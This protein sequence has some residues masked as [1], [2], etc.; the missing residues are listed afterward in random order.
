MAA[1][2]V[3]APPPTMHTLPPETCSTLSSAQLLTTPAAIAKELIDNA[4]DAHATSLTLEL[5][6]N[7]ID[8]IQLRDNGHGIPPADRP[9]TARRHCTSKIRSLA[10]VARLG[11]TSLGFR[12]EALAAVAE[13]AGTLQ[14]V[15][16]VAGEPVG[17]VMEVGSNGELKG[18]PGRKSHPVGTTVTARGFFDRFPVRK[19]AAL[20][21]ADKFIGQVKKLMMAYAVARPAVRFQLK[22]VKGKGKAGAT[23]GNWIYAPSPGKTSMQDACLAVFGLSCINQCSLILHEE[24]G[25]VVEGLVPKGDADASKIG[26]TGQFISVDTRPVGTSKG[27]LKRLVELFKERLKRRAKA[28]E[29]IKDPF[30]RL[31]IKCPTEAYDPN[32]EPAKDDIL[33]VESGLVLRVVENFFKK[34]VPDQQQEDLTQ[35]SET[36]GDVEMDSVEENSPLPDIVG[37]RTPR[38]E[39]SKGLPDQPTSQ[40]RFTLA[41]RPDSGAESSQ[42]ALIDHRENMDECLQDEA[43]SRRRDLIVPI[44]SDTDVN[45]SKVVPSDQNRDVDELS[46]LYERQILRGSH[47][48]TPSTESSHTVAESDSCAPEPDADDADPGRTID[49]DDTS[50]RPPKRRRTWKS[51]MFDFDMEDLSQENLGFSHRPEP[52]E[53]DMDDVENLNEGVAL[54]D[55]W[56]IAKMNSSKTRSSPVTMLSQ[57]STPLGERSPARLNAPPNTPKFSSPL[58]NEHQSSP[59]A[60]SPPHQISSQDD[61]EMEQ[62]IRR[63]RRSSEIPREHQHMLTSTVSPARSG[64]QNSG[65]QP[66]SGFMPINHPNNGMDLC[67]D[68]ALPTEQERTGNRRKR[69][70]GR[71][72]KPFKSP[73]MN[74]NSK[75]SATTSSRRAGRHIEPQ[76][77]VSE[78][79]G[80]G[81]HHISAN[82]PDPKFNNP[83]R[84]PNHDIR[85]FMASRMGRRQAAAV[86]PAVID[87]DYCVDQVPQVARQTRNSFA[88]ALPLN[89]E[90]SNHQE[91]QTPRNQRHSPRRVSRRTERLQ[92][93][94]ESWNQ[95]EQGPTQHAPSVQGHQTRQLRPQPTPTNA[96]AEQSAHQNEGPISTPR[97]ST[98]PRTRTR[99]RTKSRSAHLPLER[100]PR[101]SYTQNLRLTIR[102]DRIPSIAADVGKLD[103]QLDRPDWKQEAENGY[104]CFVLEELRCA[105]SDMVTALAAKLRTCVQRAGSE[106]GHDAVDV[107]VF[108]EVV[109]A[110]L[111]REREKR[112]ESDRVGRAWAA[113]DDE[114]L[115]II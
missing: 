92:E 90:E 22:V 6:A 73:M 30:L 40:N 105:H 7:T 113:E 58:R 97:P 27:T 112:P 63:L 69:P 11:G 70:A 102:P 99:T 44:R 110:A 98:R 101:D 71:V 67:N 95:H 39:A 25:F 47:A 62:S 49:C 37:L 72:N 65:I 108:E 36:A 18:R 78:W 41:I 55:P 28:F 45:S 77:F 83:E 9:L 74:L 115:N 50:D 57:R 3:L 43:T 87:P 16:R 17:A 48:A 46:L 33:F 109:A 31:D 53:V 100:S 29:G 88:A 85:D 66:R 64:N 38:L 60:S 104:D 80:N 26:G 76:S 13:S 54:S 84:D 93:P 52:E 2:D 111:S 35:L 24:E 89:P 86:T 51:N 20:K 4:L 106:E 23:R 96:N 68:T 12:G 1:H 19:Q 5:S 21:H 114:M 10:D 79:Q 14:I 56:T 75:T 34:A 61:V 107:E 15:T 94:D 91:H 103:P 8:L 81:M 82:G 59:E 42:V 32:V